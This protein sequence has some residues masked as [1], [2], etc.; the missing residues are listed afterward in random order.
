[1][2]HAEREQPT[3]PDQIADADGGDQAQG[4]GRH[5]GG[6][7]R[8]RDISLPPRADIDD[9]FIG[10]LRSQI[11]PPKPDQAR[12]QLQIRDVCT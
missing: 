4:E 8:R 10:R 1:V 11:M 6:S 12:W 9:R 7:T 3:A 5:V 2:N